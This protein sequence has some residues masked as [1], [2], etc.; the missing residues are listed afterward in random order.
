MKAYL[1]LIKEALNNQNL[2]IDVY[3]EEGIELENSTKYSEIKD[4]VENLDM[5][6]LRFYTK[7]NIYRGHA[8][9]NLC[10]DDEETVSDHSVNH[11]GSNEGWSEKNCDKWISDWFDREVMG[12]V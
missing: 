10:V 4:M 8:V 2:K 6:S 3:S 1:S 9:I 5:S 11:L 12:R 7:T